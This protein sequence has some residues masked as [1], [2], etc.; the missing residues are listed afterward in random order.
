MENYLSPTPVV[1]YRQVEVSGSGYTRG[2]KGG[3]RRADE[4]PE[5]GTDER[6]QKE[7]RM[8]GHDR[9]RIL[10]SHQANSLPRPVPLY[11]KCIRLPPLQAKI[12][13]PKI[14]GTL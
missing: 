12:R 10:N 14:L 11:L 6:G 4:K 1:G 7:E 2:T 13:L 9:T 3:P 5:G 8:R